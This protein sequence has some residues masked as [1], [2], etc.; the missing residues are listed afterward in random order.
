MR[1]AEG[2]RLRADL[3]AR[4]GVL[5]EIAGR[6]DALAPEAVR[7]ANEKMLARV[8]ELLSGVTPTNRGC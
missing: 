2:E 5:R 4:L 1:G 6:L 3:L 8:C 7:A